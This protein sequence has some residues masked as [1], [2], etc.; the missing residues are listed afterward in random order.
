M[1]LK[2]IAERLA[3][4][5]ELEVK[6]P[7]SVSHETMGTTGNSAGVHGNALVFYVA[8]LEGTLKAR[9]CYHLGRTPS[10]ADGFA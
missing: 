10:L 1:F 9:I 6:S 7:A 8:G 4:L 3:Y 5:N 2:T